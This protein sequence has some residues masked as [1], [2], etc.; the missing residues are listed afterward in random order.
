MEVAIGRERREGEEKER[1]ST[2]RESSGG[3]MVY[4]EKSL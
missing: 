2:Y 3:G 1:R 4:L